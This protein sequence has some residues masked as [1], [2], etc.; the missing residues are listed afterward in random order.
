MMLTDYYLDVKI[1]GIFE[2]AVELGVL[3]LSGKIY[4]AEAYLV[5][6][7]QGPQNTLSIAEIFFFHKG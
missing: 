4:L 7:Q 2:A 5:I 6:F 3:F 1:S